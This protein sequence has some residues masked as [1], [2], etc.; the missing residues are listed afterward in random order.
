MTFFLEIFDNLI[1]FNNNELMILFDIDGK[2]WFKLKDVYRILG[3]SNL[4]KVIYNCNIDSQYKKNYDEI[5]VVPMRVPP[6]NFQKNTIFVNE[7]G[8]YYVLLKSEKPSA[9]TFL[10]KITFEIMPQIRKTGQYI[11]DK[12]NQ[13]KINELNLKID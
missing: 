8:L 6:T 11:S 7:P 2:I 5:R 4:K 10:E 3:Y 12:N 9:K 13:N 1:K